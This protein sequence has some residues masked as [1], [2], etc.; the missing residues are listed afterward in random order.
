[1]AP[2]PKEAEVVDS[3]PPC[4]FGGNLPAHSAQFI[5][6]YGSEELSELKRQSHEFA[7]VWGAQGLPGELI[8]GGCLPSL[9]RSRTARTAR[10]L[11]GEDDS[12]HCRGQSGLINCHSAWNGDLTLI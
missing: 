10:R 3:V 2:A 4:Y 8:E 1:M 9:R 7:A 5:I 6:A 11:S 12:G